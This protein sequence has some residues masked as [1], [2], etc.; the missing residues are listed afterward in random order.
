MESNA[1]IEYVRDE[2]KNPFGVV[3]AK[4]KNEI[5]FSLCNPIDSW[6]KH[7]GLS[8]AFGR[9]DKKSLDDQISEI[10]IYDYCRR[11][12]LY[13]TIYSVKERAKKYFK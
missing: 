13:N 2:E 9:A 10:T 6:N 4:D 1:I 8:I 5:G 7:I 3:V 12:R 11:E